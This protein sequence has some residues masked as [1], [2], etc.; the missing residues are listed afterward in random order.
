MYRFKREWFMRLCGLMLDLLCIASLSLSNPKPKGIYLS[1]Y[2]Y[3]ASLSL[4]N[5]KP[6]GIHLS[7]HLSIYLL[8][9][10]ETHYLICGCFVFICLL[11][12]I[13]CFIFVSRSLF[14]NYWYL[15]IYLSMYLSMNLSH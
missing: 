3:I 1:K 11:W 10:Q 6:N 15:S 8:E 14:P 4:S 13:F 9:L 7:I 2:L 5:P 12:N